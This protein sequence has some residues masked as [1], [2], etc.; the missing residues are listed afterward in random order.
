MK[1][2]TERKDKVDV[3]VLTPEYVWNIWIILETEDV[4]NHRAFFSP[5]YFF[6]SRPRAPEVCLRRNRGVE[7]LGE[8]TI[9]N[10]SPRYMFLSSFPFR[11]SSPCNHQR[12]WDALCT[13]TP[14]YHTRI[15]EPRFLH[16]GDGD[17]SDVSSDAACF[18]GFTCFVADEGAGPRRWRGRM[19]TW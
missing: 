10:P 19:P 11:E 4:D 8:S 14:T 6:V 16:A 1:W 9:E 3:G 7:H 13:L 5:V 18:C 2:G 17:A 15:Q 12:R